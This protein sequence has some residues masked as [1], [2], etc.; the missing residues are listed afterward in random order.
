MKVS[1]YLNYLSED[2]NIYYIYHYTPKKNLE[3]IKRNGLMSLFALYHK[4]PKL[5][6]KNINHYEERIQKFCKKI[7]SI[8]MMLQNFLNLED[9]QL[10]LYFFHFGKLFPV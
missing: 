2:K 6:E 4:Y 9:F 7:P 1:S 3:F 8:L 10:N 5:Y